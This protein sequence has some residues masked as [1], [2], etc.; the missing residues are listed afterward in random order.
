MILYS[1][2][3]LFSLRLLGFLY[4][5]SISHLVGRVDKIKVLADPDGSPVKLYFSTKIIA[6]VL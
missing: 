6:P 1:K 5:L 2:I 3:I 4:S